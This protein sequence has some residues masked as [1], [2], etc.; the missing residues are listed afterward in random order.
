M[1]TN[2]KNNFK[3]TNIMNIKASLTVEA[4]IIYPLMIF[5]I[6]AL[7]FILKGVNSH[8]MIQ[9]NMTQSFAKASVRSTLNEHI[10]MATIFE[11][12]MKNR[13]IAKGI[14]FPTNAKKYDY[15]Y[16]YRSWQSI[17]PN[18]FMNQKL[19]LFNNARAK[20]WNGDRLNNDDEAKLY[21]YITPNGSV[22]HSNINC[23]YLKRSVRGIEAADVSGYRNEAGAKY[24]VCAICAGLSNNEGIVYITRYGTAYHRLNN[25]SELVREIKRVPLSETGGRGRCSKCFQ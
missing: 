10:G 9:N 1:D 20:I 6:I 4:C 7:L 17:L 24:K 18:P 2:N 19:N 5:I 22:Y 8:L 3:H 12:G 25:C 13:S 16:S 15:N 11:G 23:T 14:L 21:V